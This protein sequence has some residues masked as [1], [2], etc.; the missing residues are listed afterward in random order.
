MKITAYNRKTIIIL[1]NHLKVN[2]HSHH[3]LLHPLHLFLLHPLHH[4]QH[5]DHLLH[6]LNIQRLHNNLW[7]NKIINHKIKQTKIQF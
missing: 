7:F 2:Q 1:D 3:H 6:H 5:L 4:H